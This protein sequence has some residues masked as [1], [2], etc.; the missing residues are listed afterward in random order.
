MKK[1]LFK[2][3]WVD[4]V[5]TRMI[6]LIFYRVFLAILLKL[7]TIHNDDDDSEVTPTL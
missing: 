5:I 3:K 4:D 1:N 7:S 6:C 2:E